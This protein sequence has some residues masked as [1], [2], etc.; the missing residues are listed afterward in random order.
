MAGETASDAGVPDERRLYSLLGS[1]GVRARSLH[2]AVLEDFEW[3]L[4]LPA[5]TGRTTGEA[6]QARAVTAQTVLLEAIAALPSEV[7]REIGRAIFSAARRYEGTTVSTRKRELQKRGISPDLFKE[8][9]PRVVRRIAA[10]LLEV[11]SPCPECAE[12]TSVLIGH[13]AAMYQ[14]YDEL[15]AIGLCYLKVG[16]SDPPTAT[17]IRSVLAE[18]NANTKKRANLVEDLLLVL[19]RFNQTMS[20]WSAHARMVHCGGNNSPVLDVLISFGWP[21]LSPGG[22]GQVAVA[23]ARL[24]EPV[25]GAQLLDVVASMDPRPFTD[26]LDWASWHEP[27]E[28]L[29]SWVIP[30]AIELLRAFG[31]ADV[32][33]A[34]PM[35]LCLDDERSSDAVEGKNKNPPT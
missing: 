17:A 21:G 33:S 34:R 5:I 15:R 13:L 19:A 27:L 32:V 18:R 12:D 22:A 31:P 29:C 1:L 20:A 25:V 23:Y 9:R 6:P 24:A 30:Q 8:R 35:T 16:L 14:I 3:L 2:P 7:D 10:A 11:P 26:L 4:A 28:P